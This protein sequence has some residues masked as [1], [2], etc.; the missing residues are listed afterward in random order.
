MGAA[1]EEEE[2][3]VIMRL[4]IYVREPEAKEQLSLFQ[5]PL[6]PQWR[7]YNLDELKAAR[8]RP[9]Q[10]RV[11]LELGDEC[12][13]QHY[14]ADSTSPM[15]SIALDSTNVSTRNQYAIGMIRRDDEGEPC[16]LC[17]APLSSVIQLRPSFTAVD[18]VE[19]SAGRAAMG[20]PDADAENGD[21]DDG[22]GDGGEEAADDDDDDN[23]DDGIGPSTI[24]PVFRPAQTERE[25][26]ARRSSHAY[27]VEQRDAEP[28]CDA[29]LHP[30]DSEASKGARKVLWSP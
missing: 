4:P 18:Q 15:S 17:L 14:D 29:T 11:Q 28:W 21:D 12:N 22:G 16:A 24:A 2:D 19:A 9:E 10:G 30:P 5:Y 7:P 6:R 27:L 25:I 20:R 3:P 13:S 23:D 26:E 8:V 1:G